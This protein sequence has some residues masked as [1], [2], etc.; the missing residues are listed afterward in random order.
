MRHVRSLEAGGSRPPGSREKT[1]QVASVCWH[2]AGWNRSAEFELPLD[3]WAEFGLSRFSAARG[4]GE[5]E[6]A[7]L[8]TV[9][10]MPGRSPVVTILDAA[11]PNA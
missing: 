6:R 4:L 2:L 8:I 9:R 3:D 1:L 5:L 7:E 11:E 10:R